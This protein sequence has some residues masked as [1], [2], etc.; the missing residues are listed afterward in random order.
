MKKIFCFL[1]IVM[2]L[3]SL[4]SLSLAQNSPLMAPSPV[5]AIDTPNDSGDG[6]TVCWPVSSSDTEGVCYLISTAAS[7]EGPFIPAAK[8][9][10]LKGL[11]SD[12][13]AT[14]GFSK[15]NKQLHFFE[16]SVPTDE[17]NRPLK[18]Y[19][20]VSISRDTEI[21]PMG[22]PVTSE[23]KS[24]W[25]KFNKLNNLIITL[26]LFL[27]IYFFIQRAHKDPNLF[28]RRI[29]GL[30]AIEEAVG[31]ATE[32]GKPLLYVTG[33]YDIDAVSTI[34]SVN[35]LSH[36]SKKVASY[37]SRII[38][39]CRFAIAMTVCQEVVKEAYLNAGRPD[40]FNVHDIFYVTSDQFGYTAAVDGLMVREK[41]AAN[42]FLGTFAA[43]SIILSETGA[44]T[45]AIQIAGTDS[46]YQL[47]FFI[48]SCDYTLIG[49]ELYAAS[50]YLSREPKL[51]GSLRGQDIGK[52]MMV[53]IVLI[54]C[55]LLT[56]HEFVGWEWLMYLKY[57][58]TA[59]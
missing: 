47:P 6:Y 43:E 49:E 3:V 46:T 36:V 42:F 9:D 25:F 8:I 20:Q 32:M 54:S 58:M 12:N 53:L 27:S 15:Q 28:I 22:G 16:V 5:K 52:I 57:F 4:S 31:R 38:V 59:I 35:I 44:S 45:G 34:A 26:F 13:K 56:L 55:L 29:P 10:S 23:V 33:A 17:K 11:A 37:D 1:P 18:W 48:V 2:L 50:A 40:A 39:P 24:N 19:T 21:I 41:P 14:F 30:E 51:L 7:P